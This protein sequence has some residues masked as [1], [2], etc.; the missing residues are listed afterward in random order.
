[1]SLSV[2]PHRWP[3]VRSSLNPAPG[4]STNENH[5]LIPQ[6]ISRFRPLPLE[7]PL[8]G[9]RNCPNVIVLSPIVLVIVIDFWFDHWVI[10]CLEDVTF[11]RFR[12]GKNRKRE[13]SR[14]RLETGQGALED[15]KQVQDFSAGHLPKKSV[16][17]TP[18]VLTLRT[19]TSK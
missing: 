9:A 15:S 11:I 14:A 3:A 8:V 17:R 19:W 13:R 5:A 12:K 2:N 4:T 18:F 10:G 7:P 16:F 1:M 6:Q